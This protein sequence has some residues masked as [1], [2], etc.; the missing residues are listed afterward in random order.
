MKYRIACI[1]I[2]LGFLSFCGFGIYS[3]LMGGSA[4]AGKIED[5]KY[6]LGSHGHYTEVTRSTFLVARAIEGSAVLMFL[7]ALLVST[8]MVFSKRKWGDL[9]WNECSRKKRRM[10][11]KA[12]QSKTKAQ[13]DRR[14]GH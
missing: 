7:I 13:P 2:C 4:G 6:Y 11:D 1:L 5:G 10:P 12:I 8:D 14:V 9:K 3:D